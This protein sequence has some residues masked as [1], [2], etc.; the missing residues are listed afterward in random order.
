MPVITLRTPEEKTSYCIG[1]DM[2]ASFQRFPIEVDVEAFVEG[3]RD[4]VGN[5]EPRLTQ[6]EFT[7]LMRAFHEQLQA[8]NRDAQTAEAATNEEAGAEFREN[9]ANNP[10][11]E[12]R[13]SGLHVEGLTEGDGRLPSA[14]DTVRV[15]YRG[16]LIDGTE[17]DASYGRGEPAE[18]APCRSRQHSEPRPQE[19]R[20]EYQV[21]E[22]G[23]P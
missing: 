6:P 18:S 11:V 10:N 16:T 14:T 12:V 23:E 3:V 15:H 5:K 22:E 21:L 4:V 9:N 20:D 1:L 2:G 19:R 8:Q 7:A 13:E 17:F